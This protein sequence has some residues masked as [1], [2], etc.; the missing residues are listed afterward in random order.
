MPMTSNE[1][2]GP[3]AHRFSKPWILSHYAKKS[4]N[5]WV[6][7]Q[8]DRI[9]QVLSAHRTVEKVQQQTASPNNNQLT[10]ETS[11]HADGIIYLQ[12]QNKNKQ[13]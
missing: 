5:L 9:H 1:P 11:A 3:S 10:K 4:M 7:I 13:K 12:K 2:T 6:K 8:Q